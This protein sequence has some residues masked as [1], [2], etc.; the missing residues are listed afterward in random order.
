MVRLVF[1]RHTPKIYV[2]EALL[3]GV[4]HQSHQERDACAELAVGIVQSGMGVHTGIS[5]VIGE[6]S[7]DRFA[8]KLRDEQRSRA[9]G[10][11]GSGYLREVLVALG[12]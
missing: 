8:F 12:A 7:G 11:Q 2:F 5:G 4:S 9:I 3:L 10:Q 1:R 6:S